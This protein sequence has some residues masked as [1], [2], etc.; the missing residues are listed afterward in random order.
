[1]DVSCQNVPVYNLCRLKLNDQSFSCVFICAAML[2][3]LLLR[4]YAQCLLI[5]QQYL[6]FLALKLYRF[7]I[8]N[9]LL[10]IRLFSAYTN[11]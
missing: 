9:M 2:N 3:F 4:Y 8:L 11:E 1:M 6:I 7:L 10:Y 5:E